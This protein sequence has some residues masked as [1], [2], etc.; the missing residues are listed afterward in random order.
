MKVLSNRVYADTDGLARRARLQIF[1]VRKNNVDD[2]NL[3]KIKD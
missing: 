3:S 1:N 2:E